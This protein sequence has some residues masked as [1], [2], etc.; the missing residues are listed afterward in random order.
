MKYDKFVRTML[1]YR[2]VMDD[3]S[4]LNRMGFDFFEGKYELSNYFSRFFENTFR[5]IYT[6]EGKEWIDWFIYEGNWGQN[7]VSDVEDDWGARDS[8]G[9]KIA[10]S[11]KS[12]WELLEKDY[13]CT[14]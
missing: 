5:D 14:G 13:K 2:E 4:E 12:L 11:I 9:N 3:L 6:E 10:Y 7:P 8:E 1:M